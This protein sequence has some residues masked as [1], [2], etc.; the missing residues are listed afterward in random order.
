MA[1]AYINICINANLEVW[2]YETGEIFC[3]FKVSILDWLMSD[4]AEE[5]DSNYSV[6][7]IEASNYL[8]LES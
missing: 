2:N 1:Q 7:E 5:W 8:S 6:N 4:S 3:D